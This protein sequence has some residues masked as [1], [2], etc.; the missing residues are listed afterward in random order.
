[1][2]SSSV[3]MSENPYTRKLLSSRTTSRTW[4]CTMFSQLA[5]TSSEF[6]GP[7][8][9]VSKLVWFLLTVDSF[10][11][12][13]PLGHICS[14]S[15]RHWTHRPT[16]VTMTYDHRHWQDLRWDCLGSLLTWTWQFYMSTTSSRSTRTTGRRLH[17]VFEQPSCHG[18]MAW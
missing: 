11:R 17:Q 14:P 7:V 12:R 2:P 8:R 9:R 18:R 16:S 1:M 4:S 5:A 3:I 6:I 13:L 10:H 15:R